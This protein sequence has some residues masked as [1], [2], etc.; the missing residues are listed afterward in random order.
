MAAIADHVPVGGTAE[1]VAR[2]VSIIEGWLASLVA[3]PKIFRV[4][5][6]T[7]GLLR[8]YAPKGTDLSAHSQAHLNKVA[9][10]LRSVLRPKRAVGCQLQHAR[11][12][13]LD[14][15]NAET[16]RDEKLL[17]VP[18]VGRSCRYLALS[19]RRST[20]RGAPVC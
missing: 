1:V 3:S 9:R 6:N 4:D 8:Q 11:G 5:E 20:A 7:N 10:Q 16:S 14:A 2:L 19:A 18:D 15:L 13:Q 12:A 17:N